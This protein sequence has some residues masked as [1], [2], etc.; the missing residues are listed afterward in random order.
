MDEDSQKVIATGLTIAVVHQ[1]LLT[2][3]IYIYIYMCNHGFLLNGKTMK[4]KGNAGFM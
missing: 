2:S 4:P 1:D 3:S